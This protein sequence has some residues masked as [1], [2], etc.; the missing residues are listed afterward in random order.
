MAKILKRPN[1]CGGMSRVGH[2]VEIE[3]SVVDEGKVINDDGETGRF[4]GTAHGW[5]DGFSAL[6]KNISVVT[7]K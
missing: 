3:T 6:S 2:R 5:T 4:G 7:H 1:N